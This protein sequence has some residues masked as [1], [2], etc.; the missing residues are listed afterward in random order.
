MTEASSE[1]RL[2]KEQRRQ[3]RELRKQERHRQ[4]KLDRALVPVEV[5]Q[6]IGI[7]VR[8]LARAMRSAGVTTKL[9]VK[10]A[11]GWLAHPETAPEW[12]SEVVAQR[13]A[14]SAELEYQKTQRRINDDVE[15]LLAKHS[16]QGKLHDPSAK[17]NHLEEIHVS[18]WAYRA[19]KE[20]VRGDGAG[21]LNEEEILA[22]QAVG[23]DPYDHAT[24]PLHL[25]NCDGEGRIHC[26]DRLE[27]MRQERNIVS[28][29][30]NLT[31]SVEKEAALKALD[32][33]VG[34]AVVAW[35][36]HRVGLVTKVN[37][38]SV[39][40]R[41]VGAR[42]DKYPIEEK[43]MD[44]RWLAAVPAE[45]PAPP[46]VGDWV[47]VR[48]QNRYTR[49]GSVV[50]V[51]GPLFELSYLYKDGRHNQRWFDVGELL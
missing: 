25:K 48:E 18:D 51:D 15:D 42:V 11:R 8:P 28:R 7:G 49:E 31:A 41:H 35:R 22:L 32:L 21:D 37:K 46:A 50:A 47:T 12:F 19:A 38:V 34:D 45:T 17:F 4:R 14:R 36:G 23:V 2:S 1:H 29:V 20:L 44:P 16:A 24:W 3:E 30:E 39:K 10:Q 9:T 26:E 5:A 40:V 6:R 33:S 13:L 43:N 27:E